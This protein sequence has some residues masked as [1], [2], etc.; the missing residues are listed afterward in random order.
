MVKT[1]DHILV[2]VISS[3]SWSNAMN[4][5]NIFTTEHR[6]VTSHSHVIS[7]T[8]DVIVRQLAVNK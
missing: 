3:L 1:N 4:I 7:P 5:R 8:R 6:G 2:K